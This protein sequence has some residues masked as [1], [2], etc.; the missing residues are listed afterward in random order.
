LALCCTELRA[1][2]MSE[3]MAIIAITMKN[4]MMSMG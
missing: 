1:S 2:L 4:V 3:A